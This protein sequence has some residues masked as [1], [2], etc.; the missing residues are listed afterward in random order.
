M[1]LAERMRNSPHWV[2]V[3]VATAVAILIVAIFALIGLN[4]TDTKATEAQTAARTAQ[5]LAVSTANERR[6]ACK[7]QNMRH[8][9]TTKSLIDAAAIDADKQDTQAGKL[10]VQRRRDVTIGLIDAIAPTQDCS[11]IT[12]VKEPK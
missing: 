4:R 3:G 2:I 6:V 8:D 1:T 12:V 10:E 7:D 5:L 11:K 9:A